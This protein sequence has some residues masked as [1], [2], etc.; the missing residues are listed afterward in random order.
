MAVNLNVVIGGVAKVVAA[1]SYPF[2]KKGNLPADYTLTLKGEKAVLARTGGGTY[3]TYIYV[4]IDGKPHYLPKNV[5][6][7]AG[8]NMTVAPI[9]AKLVE[10]KVEQPVEEAAPALDTTNEVLMHIARAIEAPQKPARRKAA[11]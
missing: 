3:P 5:T 8:S 9:G 6:P 1:T 2:P 4:M 10:K 7:D 11:E